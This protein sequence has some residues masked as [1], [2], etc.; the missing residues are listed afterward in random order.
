MNDLFSGGTESADSE[1]E[2]IIDFGPDDD[3]FVGEENSNVTLKPM[4][5]PDKI[6]YGSVAAVAIVV[7]VGLGFG[8]HRSGIEMRKKNQAEAVKRLKAEELD[9]TTPRGV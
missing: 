5:W 8:V 1:M 3:K 7:G 9:K 4:P 6:V 2:P